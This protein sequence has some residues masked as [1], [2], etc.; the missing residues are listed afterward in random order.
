MARESAR[1]VLPEV[2]HGIIPYPDATPT[3]PVGHRAGTADDAGLTAAHRRRFQWQRRFDRIVAAAPDE[4]AAGEAQEPVAP[5]L[6]LAI[7]LHVPSS[8][9][10]STRRRSPGFRRAR[11]RNLVRNR[12]FA[13]ANPGAE[14]TA[15]IARYG[16][17]PLTSAQS[18][19]IA[20]F[21][22][23]LKFGF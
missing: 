12:R 8:A 7:D 22:P 13:D 11:R 4:E 19:L 16:A 3:A 23:E 15:T 21:G 1:I 2:Q 14:L 9:L 10:A 18:A 6:P 20:R 17:R 5:L